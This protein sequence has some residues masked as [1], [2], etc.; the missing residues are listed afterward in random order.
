MHSS[1]AMMMSAPSP[2]SAAMALSGEKKCDE[3]SRCE[4]NATPS[5]VTFRRS[6]RLNTWKP[7]ESVRIGAIPAHELLHPAQLA[8]G[9]DPRPQIEMVGIVQQDLDAEL[10]QDVLG[11]AFDRGHRADG[12]EDRRVDHTVWG[13]KLPD[14]CLAV[15]R[16]DLEAERHLRQ[17]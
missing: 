15:G 9:L 10:L 6:L 1:N 16:L 13:E 12:H 2:I 14:A 11:H 17:L 7:P 4:R 3:P 5:S 8:D